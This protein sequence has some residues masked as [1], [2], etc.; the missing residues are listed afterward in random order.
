MID[1]VGTW[2]PHL[3]AGPPGQEALKEEW[4]G[5]RAFDVP[6]HWRLRWDSSS[7]WRNLPCIA[8][9]WCSWPPGTN[10]WLHF[11]PSRIVTTKKCPTHSQ[12]SSTEVILLCVEGKLWLTFPL[13]VL[14]IA[15]KTFL[16]YFFWE[17]SMIC[18]VQHHLFISITPVTKCA[19][20][21]L[22]YSYFS[23]YLFPFTSKPL[24]W[25]MWKCRTWELLLIFGF[26]EDLNSL[27]HRQRNRLLEAALPP[28]ERLS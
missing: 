13:R 20:P 10:C 23:K 5:G 24:S 28:A 9:V 17:T 1:L 25:L 4:R 19:P 12:M 21:I 15:C 27:T 8:G 7:L 16:I 6:R 2:A 3:S 22:S 11:C 14:S 26:H 18:K